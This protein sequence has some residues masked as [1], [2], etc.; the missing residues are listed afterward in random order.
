MFDHLAHIKEYLSQYFPELIAKTLNNY[1]AI[2]GDN[3]AIIIISFSFKRLT[4]LTP[5]ISSKMAGQSEVV[6]GY[7]EGSNLNVI[8]RL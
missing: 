4:R 2:L 7:F 1:C 5:E 8:A 3:C 6:L